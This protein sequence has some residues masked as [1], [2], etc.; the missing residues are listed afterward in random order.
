MVEVRRGISSTHT[1][2]RL[3]LLLERTLATQDE[4]TDALNHVLLEEV[5]HSDVE[6]V[7][8]SAER[9]LGVAGSISKDD[10]R[11]KNSERKNHF[12]KLI[13]AS[14]RFSHTFIHSV[15]HLVHKSDSYGRRLDNLLRSNCQTMLIDKGFLNF[16][17]RAIQNSV[18]LKNL[19]VGK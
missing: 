7:C 19:D 12:D 1:H 13:E 8:V 3:V 9:L 6:G 15:D 4:I 17:S 2:T 14:P 10:L 5:S 11:G 16:F 18:F